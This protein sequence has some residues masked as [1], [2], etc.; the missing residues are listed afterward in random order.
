MERPDSV[1]D[2]WSLI[3]HSQDIIIT[4]REDG[5]ISFVNPAVE[6]SLGYEPEELIGTN[7]FE[8]IH[9][10]D[11]EEVAER[12]SALI[13]DP[14]RS[15]D[16]VEHRMWHEDGS[17][18][19]VESIGSNRR[20]ANLDGYV[21][22]SRDITDRKR[23]EEEL[24]ISQQAIESAH[25]GIAMADIDG[26][27]TSVNHASLAMWGYETEEDVRG[28]RI[29]EFWRDPEQ[30]EEVIRTV[31][32][33][34]EWSGELVAERRDGSTFPVSCSASIVTDENGDPL[35]LMA[36]FED[37]TTEMEYQ[38]ALKRENERLEEFTSIVSHD[39]RNPLNV[40][41]GRV[42]LAQEEYEGAHLEPV[43][44]A[45]DRMEAILEGTLALAR[46]GQTVGEK[47]SVDIE[48]VARESFE[49]VEAEDAILQVIAPFEIRGDPDRLRH[50]FENLFRNSITHGS[51]D[52]TIR[53]GRLDDQGFFV[54]DD[55]PGIP[56]ADRESVFEPGYSDAVQGTGFGLAIVDRIAEGHGWD[57]EV[58]EG[59]EGGARFEF[60][61]VALP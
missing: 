51:D 8:L 53:V 15:T 36:I 6:S 34:G 41:K 4:L 2:V 31:E 12:F 5:S 26:N 60:T 25:S 7:A 18:R 52:V 30:A 45:L 55:G 22:N 28:N 40:A 16:R 3:A 58:A 10:D 13:E 24:R 35:A 11:R 50:V 44:S 23:R 61:G 17:V 39:L 33:S 43:E 46:F 57:V 29:I 20:D 59:T 48:G 9:D 47:R 42:E 54:E 19:W 37:I 56:E 14:G 21:I 38:E 1:K 27:L 32:E 49:M